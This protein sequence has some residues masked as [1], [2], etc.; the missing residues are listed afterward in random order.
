ML[1]MLRV[2]SVCVV[3]LSMLRV[4]VDVR[5]VAGVG[6]SVRAP[7]DSLCCAVLFGFF[8]A[9]VCSRSLVVYTLHVH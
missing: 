5:I 7:C 1:S 8:I 2:P 4:V 3:V 9:R 6:R